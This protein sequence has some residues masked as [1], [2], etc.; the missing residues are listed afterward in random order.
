MKKILQHPRIVVAVIALITLFFA[1]QLPRVQLDNNNFRFVPK[2]DEALTISIDIDDTF[3]SST[4]ILVSLERKS[5][6]IFDAGFLALIQT[7]LDRIEQIDAV[8]NVNSIVSS[9]YIYGEEDAIIV[10]K[11]IPVDFTGTPEEIA[12]LQRRVFSWDMYARALFSDDFTATQILVPLDITIQNAGRPDVVASYSRVRDIAHEVFSQ[13]ANVYVAGMPVISATIN[14]SMKADLAVLIPIVI[15]VVLAIVYIPL[16]RVSFVVYSIVAV[17]VAV[18]WAIGAMP[19]VGIKLSIITTVLPVVLIAIGNSYG[20]HVI[21]HYMEDAP[22]SIAAMS[23]E[24]H[25]GYIIDMMRIINKPV[26]LATITTF[27]SFIA[28]CFTRVVPIREFGY[29]AAFGVLMSYIIAMTLT[30]AILILRGPKPLFAKNSPAGQEGLSRRSFGVAELFT[31]VVHKKRTVLGITAVFI[32]VSVFGAVRVVMDNIFV[33]YFKPNT[34]IVKS[35][36]FIRE[37]FGGTKVI[38]IMFQAETPEI[39]LHPK[40]LAA[41]EGL[42]ARLYTLS[43]TGKV[44]GFTDLI[45]R[46]NQVYHAEDESYYEIP[47]LPARY[48]KKTVDELERVVASYLVLLSGD[49]DSYANDPLEPTAIRSM[50]QLRTLGDIDTEHVVN[51]IHAYVRENFPQNVTVTVGGPA[52]VERS[53]N[54]LVVQSVWTSMIIAFISLFIIVSLAN[55]SFAAGLIGVVPLLALI[56][57]NFAVMG[58]AGI[59]LNI[60]TAMIFSLIMGIGID[61]TIHF[62]EAYKREYQKAVQ[63]G[64]TLDDYAYLTKAYKTSGIAVLADAVSTGT[65]FIVLLLSRFTMLADFGLL[66][67]LSLYMSALVGL[68]VVPAL[69]LLFKPKFITGKNPDKLTTKKS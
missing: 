36:V 30:P 32:G 37:K 19:L 25:T 8:G 34:D 23:R 21:V 52:L 16:R 61:Y 56:L 63:N 24:E 3:G 9:D 15:L 53:I 12:E 45:K 5:G 13:E 18:V 10:E 67:A 44:T 35:D 65:G 59:R 28:F 47:L 27:V 41:I 38:S 58:F 2:N 62:L 6:T 60:G 42:N 51:E 26:F 49:I 69:L 20:L 22:K 39:I 29:F 55:R 17:V 40:T 1:A 14:E 64:I 11:L 43:E 31:R 57:V 50:L 48:N 4:L 54:N 68:V 66:V 33:E 7:Y 46:I